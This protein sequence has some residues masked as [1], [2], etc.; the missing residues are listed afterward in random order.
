VLLRVRLARAPAIH[1]TSSVVGD[2]NPNHEWATSHSAKACT[3]AATTE[4]PVVGKSLENRCM[5]WRRVRLRPGRRIESSQRPVTFP[6]KRALAPPQWSIP[7]DRV[8]QGC[9]RR[10]LGPPQNIPN[11]ISD[12]NCDFRFTIS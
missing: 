1:P 3:S 2:T 11:P 5:A 4:S 7:D 8:R 6:S 9:Y 12:I 10:P